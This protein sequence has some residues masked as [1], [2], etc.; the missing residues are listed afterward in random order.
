MRGEQQILPTWSSA[1][2]LTLSPRKVSDKLLM[3]GLDEQQGGLELAE[4]P[5]PE[6]GEQWHKA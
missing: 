4:Q 3:C 6:G 1:R 5:G 2:P